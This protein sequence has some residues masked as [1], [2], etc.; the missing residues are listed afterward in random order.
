MTKQGLIYKVYKE[1]KKDP[2]KNQKTNKK[3]PTYLKLDTQL[4][5]RDIELC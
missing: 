2:P 4:K 1:P 3:T 5:Y